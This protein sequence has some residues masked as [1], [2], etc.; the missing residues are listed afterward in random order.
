MKL[1]NV[2]A[3]MDSD[4][5]HLLITGDF[6]LQSFDWILWSVPGS[7]FPAG[8]L[9]EVLDD[10]FYHTYNIGCAK[11]RHPLLWIWQL[12]DYQWS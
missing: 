6:N 4:S 5:S 9:P 2:A 7:D 10:A 1:I 11:D 12:Y 8:S 3:E